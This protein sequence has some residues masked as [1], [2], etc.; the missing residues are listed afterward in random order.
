MDSFA[1]GWLAGTRPQLRGELGTEVVYWNPAH[2]WKDRW[3]SSL[4]ES[5]RVRKLRTRPKT[6][7]KIKYE[8]IIFFRNKIWD[9]GNTM[10][11]AISERAIHFESQR[12]IPVQAR[13]HDCCYMVLKSVVSHGGRVSDVYGESPKQ[14]YRHF[15][16]QEFPP[17]FL[18]NYLDNRNFYS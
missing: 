9:F 17:L 12:K 1:C 7:L 15:T 11:A 2:L 10:L 14:C 8:I 18:F 16:N 4:W 5:K 3:N 13:V 6:K